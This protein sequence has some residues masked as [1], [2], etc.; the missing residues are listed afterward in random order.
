MFGRGRLQDQTWLIGEITTSMEQIK[1][2][3]HL[4]IR[5][6]Y[7]PERITSGYYVVLEMGSVSSL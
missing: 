4:L 3:N 2:T 5:K 7:P 6:T 1:S